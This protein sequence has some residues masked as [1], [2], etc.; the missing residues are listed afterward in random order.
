M[1]Q[2]DDNT[3]AL[4]I[5]KMNK[6]KQ[7]YYVYLNE[8]RLE[9][10]ALLRKVKTWTI[11]DA[12][13]LQFIVHKITGT[14]STYGYANITDAARSLEYKV[15][16]ANL[17]FKMSSAANPNK[18]QF[19]ISELTNLI[20]LCTD[21]HNSGSMAK[22]EDPR[23]GT[24]AY[25][26]ELEPSQFNN[27]TI[28]IVDDNEITRQTLKEAL[29]IAGFKII[30]AEDGDDAL[31]IMQEKVPDLLILDRMMPHLDGLM[32]LKT[33]RKAKKLQNVPVIF[34]T[35]MYSPSDILEAQK[36]GAVDY[37]AKP[38][39]P[40]EMTLRCMRLFQANK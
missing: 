24:V 20:R 16:Y 35:A 15:A 29:K 9:L 28:M 11:E 34:L 19:I 25:E 22:M 21:I 1:E 6:L 27:K 12:N 39:D 40:H 36:L 5:E 7:V 30:T 4:F 13:H 26:E 18:N 2:M 10:E 31:L 17:E 23:W 14:G 8:W 37:I 38:F 32:V 33:M 3:R